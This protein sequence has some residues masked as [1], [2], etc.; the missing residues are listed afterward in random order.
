MRSPRLSMSMISATSAFTS[1]SSPTPLSA[2]Q[3]EVPR[4]EGRYGKSTAQWCAWLADRAI[5]GH[6]TVGESSNG[7][8]VFA[9][10]LRDKLGHALKVGPSLSLELGF[11]HQ[12]NEGCRAWTRCQTERTKGP[13]SC[14]PCSGSSVRRTHPP[15]GGQPPGAGAWGRHRP[16]LGP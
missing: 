15:L 13:V 1:A 7:V 12:A 4:K 14:M 10:R 8:R 11:R 9:G 2:Q 5:D 16:T 6:V 3:K